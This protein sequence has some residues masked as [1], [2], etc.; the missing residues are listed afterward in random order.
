MKITKIKHRKLSLYRTLT[1]LNEHRDGGGI[2]L[3]GDASW[4]TKR[5]VLINTRWGAWSIMLNSK[6]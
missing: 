1:L 3:K 6:S 4:R 2:V 5:G